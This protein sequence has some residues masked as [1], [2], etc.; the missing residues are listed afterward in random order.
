MDIIPVLAIAQ[1]A[2]ETGLGTSR[3][4]QEGNAY[5]VSGRGAVME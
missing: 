2:K 4:A 3:F 1:A 5:L